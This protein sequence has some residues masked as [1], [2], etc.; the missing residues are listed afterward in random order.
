VLRHEVAVL[1]RQVT[2]PRPTWLGVAVLGSVLTSACR[3]QLAPTLA[4]LP[5][6]AAALASDSVGAALA[7]PARLGP[8][9]GELAGAAWAAFVDAMG[10]SALVGA[11]IALLGAMVALALLPARPQVQLVEERAPE[12]TQP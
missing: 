3:H 2:R 6:Q 1:P 11:A 5:D 7:V 12:T 8:N 10:T 9:G 4:W